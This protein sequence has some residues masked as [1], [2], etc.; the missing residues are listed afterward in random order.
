MP[1]AKTVYFQGLSSPFYSLKKTKTAQITK[2][3]TTSFNTFNS[4]LSYYYL[5]GLSMYQTPS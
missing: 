4:L 3:F 5:R 2:G 1:E